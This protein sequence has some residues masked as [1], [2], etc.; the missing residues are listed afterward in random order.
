MKT[1]NHLD[2]CKILLIREILSTN[3]NIYYFS[4][5]DNIQLL[6]NIILKFKGEDFYK[7]LVLLNY[8]NYNGYFFQNPKKYLVK[9][10]NNIKNS[11]NTEDIIESYIIKC[12]DLEIG[13]EELLNIEILALNILLENMI[14]KGY[15]DNLL[16]RL[17][18]VKLNYFNFTQKKKEKFYKFKNKIILS[19]GIKMDLY[20]VLKSINNGNFKFKINDLIFIKEYYQE[21]IELLQN[22]II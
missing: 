1:L 6:T 16:E 11:K 19:D 3:N 18:M 7:L 10:L 4:I 13:N 12:L 5:Y 8:Q 20:K 21:E 15:K 9:L 14:I 22:K 2:N 17:E